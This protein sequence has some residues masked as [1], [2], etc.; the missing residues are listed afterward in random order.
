MPDPVKTEDIEVTPPVVPTTP[1]VLETP[2]EQTFELVV[3]GEKRQVTTEE[4]KTLAQKAAGADKK[5]SE[6]SELRKQG[7]DGLRMK[8][9][10][11]RIGDAE[12]TP[13]ETEILELSTMIGVDPKEFKQYLATTE[14][15]VDDKTKPSAE[16]DLSNVDEKT[17]QAILQ[18][19]LGLSPAEARQR[20]DRSFQRDVDLAKQEIKKISD[21]AVDK[22]E[23]FGKMIVGQ[24]RADRVS[25][26][27]EMVEEDV[28]R[29]IQDG[30]PFGAEL[31]AA[32]VQ[33][34]R[35]YLTKY[36]IPSRP[37]GYPITMG[38]GPGGGLPSEVQ[39]DDPI[40]RISAVAPGGEENFV[41]RALQKVLKM[42]RES[43][44]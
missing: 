12:H 13:S 28:L 22:D 32:S 4:M 19:A 9:L 27:K 18:K 30:T 39:S 38:L 25:V 7:E 29:R 35:A 31:V 37:A 44:Q 14:E 8:E 41:H 23:I 43:Q 16:V 15:P 34:I 6:A 1:V 21:E 3:D 20:L 36:G 42:R 26:I 40:K 17:A 5:F 33:K 24:K 10:I 2:K 11:D